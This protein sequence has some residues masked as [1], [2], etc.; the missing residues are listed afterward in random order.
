MIGVQL[1]SIAKLF[2]WIGRVFSQFVVLDHHIYLED[3]CVD[4]VF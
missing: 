4:D 3:G 2:D 1:G